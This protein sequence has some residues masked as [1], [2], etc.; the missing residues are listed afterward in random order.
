[1]SGGRPLPRHCEYATIAGPVTVS[2]VSG[3]DSEEWQ[4]A[5]AGDNSHHGVKRA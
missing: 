3:D 4:P 5:I 1:M 2:V